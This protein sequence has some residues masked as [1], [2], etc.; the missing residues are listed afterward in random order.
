MLP[1]RGDLNE[2]QAAN[3]DDGLWTDEGC[4]CVLNV[5]PRFGFCNDIDPKL[6]KLDSMKEA[7]RFL[8]KR[9]HDGMWLPLGV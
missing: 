1:T 8:R 9:S 7:G 2:R 3:L 5:D 6:P 4:V